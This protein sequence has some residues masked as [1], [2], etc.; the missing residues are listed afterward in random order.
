MFMPDVFGK[1]E[2]KQS[3]RL[4]LN[5][6]EIKLFFWSKYFNREYS[7]FSNDELL[8]EDTRDALVQEQEA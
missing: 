7:V 5:I 6:H 2:R 1:D 4:S 8:K 3:I